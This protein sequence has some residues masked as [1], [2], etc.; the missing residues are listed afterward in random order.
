[1]LRGIK[2]NHNLSKIKY[3]FSKHDNISKNSFT[4]FSTFTKFPANQ[5]LYSSNLENDSCGVGLVANMKKKPSRKIVMDANEMLV[6]M[7]H[8]GGCGCEENAGDGAGNTK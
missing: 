2:L 5:G 4:K 3:N 1:M 6:R 7:S 8:R